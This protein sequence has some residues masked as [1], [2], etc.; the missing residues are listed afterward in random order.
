MQFVFTFLSYFFIGLITGVL[1]SPQIRMVMDNGVVPL[2]YDGYT[3][4]KGQ[5]L[6]LIDGASTAPKT[7]VSSTVEMPQ[8]NKAVA[9]DQFGAEVYRDEQGLYGIDE[10]G[11]VYKVLESEIDYFYNN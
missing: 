6:T 5:F 7:T 9:V 3:I 4:V 11:Q 1:F 8:K 2:V 10:S